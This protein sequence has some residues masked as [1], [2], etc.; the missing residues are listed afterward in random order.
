[1]TTDLSINGSVQ[2]RS[3]RREYFRAKHFN[4]L[5][6]IEINNFFFLNIFSSTFEDSRAKLKKSKKFR[7]FEMN[8]Q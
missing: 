3:E 7:T 5:E 6:I 8:S 2:N 1:M 4:R